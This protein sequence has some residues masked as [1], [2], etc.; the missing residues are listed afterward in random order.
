MAGCVALRKIEAGICEMK[1]LYVRP[2]FRGHGLGRQ[3]VVAIIAD[4]RRIGYKRMRLDT[5]PSLMKEAVNVYR[6][7]GFEEI[8]PYYSN[9]VE[10]TLYM[11]LVL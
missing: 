8:E 9:P 11:E 6:S 1:R 2:A 7:L 10:G 3:L 5:L 4:A